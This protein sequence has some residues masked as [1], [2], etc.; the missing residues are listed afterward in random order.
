MVDIGN[1]AIEKLVSENI[2][3]K[4]ILRLDVL[5]SSFFVNILFLI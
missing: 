4:I 3:V 1:L 2:L 5:F